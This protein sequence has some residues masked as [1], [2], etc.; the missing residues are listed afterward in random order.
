MKSRHEEVSLNRR[1]ALA[2]LAVAPALG[3][4]LVHA[5]S[6]NPAGSSDKPV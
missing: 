6:P 3:M 1:A 2:R 4:G 5:Q